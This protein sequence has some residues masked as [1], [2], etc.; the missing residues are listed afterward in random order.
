MDSY[1]YKQCEIIGF[2]DT[3]F[4]GLGFFGFSFQIYC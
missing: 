4:V 2:D 1:K 3:G